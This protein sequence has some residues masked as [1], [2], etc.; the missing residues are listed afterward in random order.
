MLILSN[1]DVQR[2]LSMEVCVEALENAYKE[3]AEDRAINR[4]R[5]DVL[6]PKG[7]GS[8]Y[9][10]KSMEGCVASTG[11]MALR[12][13]SD[14][15]HWPEHN[16]VRRRE[17]IPAA[18]GNKWV[19][20]VELFSIETGEPLA[21]FPDGVIQM[22]RV[23]GTGGLSAKYLARKD[24]SIMALYGSGWQA[25][26]AAMAAAAVRPLKEIRV[27]S[28]NPDNR[29]AF[30]EE[31]SP[32]VGVEIQPVETPEKAAAGAHIVSAATNALAPVFK[33]AWL[34]PGAH[35]INVRHQELDEEAYRKSARIF[36][37][38]HHSEPD[39]YILGE[40]A[41]IPELEEGW[42]RPIA[43]IRWDEQPTLD[44]LVSGRAGGRQSEDEITCFN[45][46]IG[47]G[48]Q[49][50]AVGARVIEM[51]REQGLGHEIPTDWF[52]EDVHP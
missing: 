32:K 41:G 19:G 25:R 43:G 50:G 23:G 31:M 39:H 18:P 48:F 40:N 51:A 21:I 15:V 6:I 37:N 42:S 29:R 10:F 8:Y 17:K 4:P 7:A 11:V 1:D 33:G 13:N 38:S 45:N 34:E 35:M 12:I 49:F 47:L 22:M 5:S 52:L 30:A 16:G 9:G 28:P 2:V 44:Q 46:N 24:A 3:L 14:T 27:Y 26:S 36:V 20:L